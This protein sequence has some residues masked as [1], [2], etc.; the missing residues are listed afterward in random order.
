MTSKTMIGYWYSSA[1]PK[2]S[3]P[4][5]NS[6]I[7]DESARQLTK[8][9]DLLSDPNIK[10]IAYRGFSSCRICG[11]VNGSR[12]WET[13]RYII[14]CGLPHYITEHNVLVPGLLEAE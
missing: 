2:L 8:L 6:T 12:E 7:G 5:E 10:V 1:T 14:P 13:S 11:K 9:F 4:M 3:K